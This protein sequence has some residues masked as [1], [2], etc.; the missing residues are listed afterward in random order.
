MHSIPRAYLEHLLRRWL[1]FLLLLLLLPLWRVCWWCA[2]LSSSLR[3]AHAVMIRNVLLF[4]LF[5]FIPGTKQQY[6]CCISDTT[7]NTWYY[8]RT[9]GRCMMLPHGTVGSHY[10]I[11]YFFWCCLCWPYCGVRHLGYC[12]CRVCC[13]TLECGA[14]DTARTG[15]MSSIITDGPNTASAGIMISTEPLA[16]QAVPAV[17]TFEKLGV[18]RVSRVLDP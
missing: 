13:S 18:L 7:V 8:C 9:V 16:Q 10:G 4:Q 17:Q 11:Q 2:T 6:Y 1:L 3:K 14:Q 15:S 5:Y 12:W